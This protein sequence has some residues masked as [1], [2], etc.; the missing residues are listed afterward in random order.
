MF[1]FL[2][3]GGLSHPCD[4]S[5]CIDMKALAHSSLL[6]VRLSV[7]DCQLSKSMSVNKQISALHF[8]TSHKSCSFLCALQMSPIKVHLNQVSYTSHHS[9][10]SFLCL[11]ELSLTAGMGFAPLGSVASVISM[12]CFTPRR[13]TSVLS[14]EQAL[15]LSPLTGSWTVCLRRGGRMK[16]FTIHV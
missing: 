14:R 7:R 9:Q 11:L 5:Y 6:S 1:N 12:L 13:S 10:D 2:G 8:I 16:L 15:R 3:V 4:H